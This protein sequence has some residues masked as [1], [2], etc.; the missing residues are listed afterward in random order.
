MMQTGRPPTVPTPVTTPSAGVSA[1]SLRAKSQSSWKS[2]PGS[3]SRC[4][5]SRTKSL[6][7]SRSLS[8]Y[9]TWPCSI[10]ARSSMYRSSPVVTR[11]SAR[12]A[13]SP[14]GGMGPDDDDQHTIP[15]PR[16]ADHG[17]RAGGRLQIRG[18][19]ARAPALQAE[20]K[21]DG[22]AADALRGELERALAGHRPALRGSHRHLGADALE[23]GVLLVAEELAQARHELLE[24]LVPGAADAVARGGRRVAGE[25]DAGAEGYVL[26]TRRRRGNDQREGGGEDD[27][28]EHR[29]HG[30]Q[31]IAQALA[32]VVQTG[33]HGPHRNV[34][35]LRDLAVRQPFEITQHD[36]GAVLLRQRG[37]GARD[38]L[39][40]LRAA[41]RDV[42]PRALIRH[43][44]VPVLLRHALG[45]ERPP[46]RGAL[47][48]SVGRHVHHDAEE[49]RVERRLAAERRQG[50]PGA[51]EGVL[52]GVPGLLPVVQDVEGQPPRTIAILG[53]Q[54]LECRDVAVAASLDEDLIG[55]IHGVRIPTPDRKSVV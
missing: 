20:A 17:R 35:H 49:P 1:S 13:P 22:V 53:D 34:E 18:E 39:A 25:Q 48:R 26:L 37:Q 33:H 12:R 3:S 36:N 21:T 19:L 40:L 5:R 4:R 29:E 6:P 44:P 51:D 43:Q 32:G 47:A 27:G 54:R 7:S 14:G 55:G 24:P 46:A 30:P 52:R 38:A 15:L 50:L 28:E 23:R 45:P 31:D 2:V 9:L 41:G 11:V 42:R 8:R 16:T 10:R